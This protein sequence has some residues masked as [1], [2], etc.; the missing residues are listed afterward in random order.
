MRGFHC[1]E[2]HAPANKKPKAPASASDS[3][4]QNLLR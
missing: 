4:S 3:K 1:Q 2:H